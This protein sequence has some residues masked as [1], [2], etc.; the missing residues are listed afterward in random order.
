MISTGPGLS[1]F[2]LICESLIFL[3]LT[4][5]PENLLFMIMAENKRVSPTAQTPFKSWVNQ[6]R[7]I[8]LSKASL[9][10]KPKVKMCS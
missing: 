6:V 5:Y 7:D 4:V 10:A 9:M 3:E 1:V 2:A 8:P